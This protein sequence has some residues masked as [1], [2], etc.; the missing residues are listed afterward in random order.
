MVKE[1]YSKKILS[2]GLPESGVDFFELDNIQSQSIDSS[3]IPASRTPGL[4]NKTADYALVYP[5]HDPEIA[6]VYQP[7]LL[8]G[9]SPSQMTDTYTKHLVM[10]S[11][12][13]VK[14]AHGNSVEALTQLATW[15]GSGFTKIRESNVEAGK[16]AG[17]DELQRMI[18]Y[19]VVGHIWDTYMAC[20]I[21]T[22][23]ERVVSMVGP[24]IGLSTTTGFYT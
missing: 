2:Y 6:G 14:P 8:A 19:T 7:L 3:Y 22:D 24:L 11:G 1:G 21:E 15:F 13:E 4:I 17:I 12:A 5:A 16:E 9:Y 10:A 20:D 23:G 18:G